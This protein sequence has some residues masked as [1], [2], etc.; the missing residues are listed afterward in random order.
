MTGTIPAART[1]HKWPK[2]GI[3]RIPFWVYTDP[4]VYALEQKKIFQ[5]PTWNY[6]GLEAEVAKPGDFKATFIGDTPVVLTRAR[7]QSLHVF[8][9]KCA[10]RG[11][12]V[13]RTRYGNANDFTGKLVAGRIPVVAATGSQ[14]YAETVEITARRTRAAMRCS[15]S[16]RITSSR[17]SRASSNTSPPSAGGPR[18]R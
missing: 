16:R 13:C 6:V 4:E 10:H 18:C 9:N 15:S 8:V 3:S 12:T 14:S 7:D 17:R 1:E 2:E 11:A 5:G